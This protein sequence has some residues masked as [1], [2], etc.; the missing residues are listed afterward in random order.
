M[1]GHEVAENVA[2]NSIAFLG[3]FG[4]QAKKMSMS[5]NSDENDLSD[6]RA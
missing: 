3:N 6:I 2:R 4:F 1:T 5:Q